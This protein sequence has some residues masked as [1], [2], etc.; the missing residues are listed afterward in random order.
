MQAHVDEDV[1]AQTVEPHK[2]KGWSWENWGSLPN[3][4]FE[5][6]AALVREGFKPALAA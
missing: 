1:V 6:L 3:P 2:C 4:L 5:P